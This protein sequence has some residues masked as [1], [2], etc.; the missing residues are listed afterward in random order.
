MKMANN[1]WRISRL[2][3]AFI[4][5]AWMAAT[6]NAAHIEEKFDVLQTRTGTYKNVTVTTHA[7]NY[8]FIMHADGLANIRISDLS[9]ETQQELGYAPGGTPKVVKTETNGKTVTFASPKSAATSSKVD[10]SKFK[11]DPASM[12]KI[13]DFVKK[14][15]TTI[16]FAILG[17]M[18][19]MYLFV[20]YCM[21][22]ICKK[23]GNEPG[24]MVWLPL[25]Q[26]FPMFRAAGMSG[27]WFVAL[28]IPVL[29]VVTY[30]LWAVKIVKAREKNGIMALLLILP[31]TNLFALA[32]LAFSDGNASSSKKDAGERPVMVLQT[33]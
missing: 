20:S 16:L 24:V 27:V 23:T 5:I 2:L 15:S 18:F 22:L 19:A 30:I 31:V 14:L 26:W 8:I 1:L 13:D 3:S 29:N 11:L 7:K 25:L 12:K 32:Y 28:F 17:G 6:A 33:A 9:L 10:F 4:S 21:M